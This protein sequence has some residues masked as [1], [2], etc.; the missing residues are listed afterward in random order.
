MKLYGSL[1]RLVAVLFRKDNQDIT[2]RPNQSVSYTAARD[3]QLPP[4][5]A[6]SVLVSE[7]ATQT[8]TNKTMSGASNTFSNIAYASLT[9]T[10][11]IVNADIAA[12]A[13]IAYSKLALTNSIVNADIN[14]AAAIAYSK[15]NLS[16]SIVNADI[17]AGAAIAYSKLAALTANRALQS[18]G[19]G[20]VSASTVTSTE[21]GYVSGVTSAIQT[22]FTGKASTALDNLSA[23]AI[24]A[25]LLPAS[26]NSIALGSSSKTW[27]AVHSHGEVLYG[28]TSG[29]ITV[30]A[31][32]TTSSYSIKWPSAQAGT[33]GFVLA[34]DAAGNLSW[35]SN[36]ST[37]S[38]KAT[39]AD[40]D[41]A[42]KSIT[43]S[44]GTRDVIVQVYD[45]NFQTIELDLVTRTDANTLDITSSEAP[46]TGMSWRVLILAV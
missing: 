38:F 27:S 21:L 40:T 16:A 46:A 3:V 37:N 9:L 43:H 39:W 5:N 24:N 36:A 26:T 29:N 28:S 25:A 32:D 8:L 14:S 7:N 23:V 4:Q 6:N 15:L 31:A 22:Q 42:S 2:V 19:S 33:A 18:D 1:S 11:S 35:V 44:L 10:N 20:F 41:G 13:A 45:E 12:A 34:N 30:A 17:A